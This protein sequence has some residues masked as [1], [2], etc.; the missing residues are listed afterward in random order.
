MSSDEAYAS[1]LDK[2][3]QPL[4]SAKNTTTSTCSTSKSHSTSQSGD[5]PASLKSLNATFT[6][7]SDEPFEP[8]TIPISS[9]SSAVPDASE[10]AK[11]IEEEGKAVEELSMEEFDPKGEYGEVV[12][13]VKEA[14]SGGKGE[15]KFFRVEGKSRTRVVYHVVGLDKEGG[16]LIGVRA[17]SV[18]T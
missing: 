14:A 11:L 17:V 7:E 2:A 13:K 12:G 9:S 5:I 16:R 4:G 3:N 1:F 10:F 6:S 8:F 18:E 15:V